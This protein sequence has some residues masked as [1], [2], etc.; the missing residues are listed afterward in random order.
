[1]FIHVHLKSLDEQKV[2]SDEELEEFQ[3]QYEELQRKEYAKEQ[4]AKEVWL[5]TTHLQFHV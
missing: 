4:R 5:S 1:M 2:Y 3:R